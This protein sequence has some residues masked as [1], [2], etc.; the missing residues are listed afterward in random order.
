MNDI[1]CCIIQIAWLEMRRAFRR[2]HI[3]PIPTLTLTF[4]N[5][6]TSSLWPRVWLT[7]FIENRTWIGA[8][9]L[10]TNIPIYQLSVPEQPAWTVHK[11]F[12]WFNRQKSVFTVHFSWLLSVEISYDHQKSEAEK[13][14]AKKAE[15]DAIEAYK[16]T[17]S[18][19][20]VQASESYANNAT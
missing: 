16:K 17:H 8:R 15:I 2:A 19:K 6:I 14:A 1:T 10:F 4:Q 3:P 12:A 20:L 18:Q 11:L 9:K 7:K 5:F 13:Q